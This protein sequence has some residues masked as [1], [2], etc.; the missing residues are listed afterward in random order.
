MY[1]LKNVEAG[2]KLIN[3]EEPKMVVKFIDDITKDPTKK[4]QGKTPMIRIQVFSWLVESGLLE[5]GFVRNY[6]VIEIA[7]SLKMKLTGSND[8]E[9]KKARDLACRNIRREITVLEK[10]GLVKTFKNKYTVYKLDRLPDE[11]EKEYKRRCKNTEYGV[12]TKVKWMVVLQDKF[13]SECDRIGCKYTDRIS[14]EKVNEL[15]NNGIEFSKLS[16]STWSSYSY[17][18]TERTT[19]TCTGTVKVTSN[20]TEIKN[21]IEERKEQ[22][23]E[24]P[25]EESKEEKVIEKC[26]IHEE[27]ESHQIEDFQKSQNATFEIEEVNIE[28]N[29]EENN[30]VDNEIF[31]HEETLEE[32]QIR[33]DA[34]QSDIQNNKYG[35]RFSKTRK[36][37]SL[38]LNNLKKEITLR[39][40][41]ECDN[42]AILKQIFID[43]RSRIN[44]K[45]NEI[46]IACK[47]KMN[48]LQN[49]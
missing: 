23:E 38:K 28:V 6:E 7:K 37:A 21:I 11:D 19:M 47:E 36:E 9:T 42:I 26:C 4:R 49:K 18:Y 39:T 14:A 30:K 22:E 31:N 5:N 43:N 2:A 34:L 13:Y 29:I 44:G 20:A 17:N 46:Q 10:L 15:N 41:E 25:I 48:R 16:K 40:I 1:T 45:P 3:K 27:S 8:E 32:M 33:Y 35:E 24:L 12:T